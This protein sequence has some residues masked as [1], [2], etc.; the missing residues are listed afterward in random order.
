MYQVQKQNSWNSTGKNLEVGC[1]RAKGI[2]KS[3]KFYHN[4]KKKN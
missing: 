3:T 4:K 1:I 2:L